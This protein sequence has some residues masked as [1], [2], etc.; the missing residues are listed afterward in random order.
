MA[1]NQTL[2]NYEDHWPTQMGAW[3]RDEGKVILRGKELFSELK[4]LR[5]MGL[6]LYGITGRIFDENAVRLFEAIWS[7]STSYPDPRL[8]PNRIAAF[9]GTARS[10]A[11]SGIGAAVAIC[12]AVNFGHRANI[13]TMDFF[14]RTKQAVDKGAN[15]DELVQL[16]MKKYRGIP[17]YGRIIPPK[18]DERIGPMM[19]I[20]RKLGF[21]EGEYVR[22]AFQVEEALIRGRWRRYINISGL[23]AALVAD[24]GLT[25]REHYVYLTLCFTGGMIPCFIDAMDKPEGCFFPLRCSRVQYEGQAPRRQWE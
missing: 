16:E 19:E 13:K 7:I 1:N 12:E 18:K 6:L 11:T 15:L 20:A 14:L 25:V 8:W 21:A 23:A 9:A 2:L 22:L 5:W 3:R 4:D 24:Q 10:T 17:G